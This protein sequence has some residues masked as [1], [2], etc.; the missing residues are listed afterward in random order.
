MQIGRLDLHGALELGQRERR[1]LGA[2]GQV[3]QA[4]A[5]M[6]VA[7]LRRDGDR[8]LPEGDVGAPMLKLRRC[9]ESQ[10]HQNRS[11]G[12]GQRDLVSQPGHFGGERGQ[13]GGEDQRGA[14]HREIGIMIGNGG[15]PLVIETQPTEHGKRRKREEEAGGRQPGKLSANDPETH[16]DADRYRPRPGEE[17]RGADGRWR[18]AVIDGEIGRDE[19]F[20]AIESEGIGS[21]QR[22]H[23]EGQFGQA[24]GLRQARHHRE[25]HRDRE[26]RPEGRERQ[27]RR[28]ANDKDIQ[29]EKE[30]GQRDGRRLGK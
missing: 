25:H 3:G 23:P 13:R 27:T 4:E 2:G 29:H 26:Q 5:L 20:V 8:A 14:E 21:D 1:L 10:R 17:S 16:G 19:H 11:A 6:G 18:T 30:G 28:A 7:A 9:S 12:G 15:D 24:R 22:P